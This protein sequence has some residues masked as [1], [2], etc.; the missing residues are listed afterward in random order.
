[1]CHSVTAYLH[2]GTA[3]RIGFSLGLH[4]DLALKNKD[5]LEWERGRRLWWTIYV[6]DTEMASRF[7]YPSAIAEG[8]LFMTTPPAT[9]QV[10]L[11]PPSEALSPKQPTDPSNHPRTRS[12]VRA[13][14]PL[15]ATK[16]S[17]SA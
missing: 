4:R 12:S 3:M 14:T 1:M 9:E 5:A 8:S 2:L 10:S 15:S 11:Q 17:S 16:P 13:P 7:G 6:L